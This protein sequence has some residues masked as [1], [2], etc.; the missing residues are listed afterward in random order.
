MDSNLNNSPELNYSRIAEA[1]EFI[2]QNFK[3][4]PELD[5]IAKSVHLSPHHFH[6]LFTH[7]A[8][9]SPKKFLQ[10]I[11]TRYAKKI[12]AENNAATLFEITNETGLSSTSRLHDLFIKLEGMTPAEY[13]YGG[14]NLFIQYSFSETQFGTTIVA[15]TK[16]GIC[17]LA[18]TDNKKNAIRELKLKFPNAS[19]C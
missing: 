9:T 15:S 13:K 5:E 1:I 3:Q 18:F 19:L 4:Q 17:H 12:L 16:K 11:T 10:Y 6:R 14:Q 8:G 2:Q 7:W